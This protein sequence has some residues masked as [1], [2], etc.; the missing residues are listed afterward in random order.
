MPY[1]ETM[2]NGEA[3]KLKET[4]AECDKRRPG[5][6]VWGIILLIVGLVM[7]FMTEV[8]TDLLEDL[9][10]IDYYDTTVPIV[11][12]IVWIVGSIGMILAFVFGSIARKKHKEEAEQRLAQLSRGSYP[13]PDSG[14]GLSGGPVYGPTPVPSSG[15]YCSVCGTFIPDTAAFCPKCGK[16]KAG[17]TYDPTPAPG[18]A[19]Y[20][21]WN[22]EPGPAPEPTPYSG[23]NPEPAPAPEPV[24]YSDWNPEPGP[25][26][27]PPSEP[28]TGSPKGFK[29]AGR[30]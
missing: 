24:P 29:P 15:T 8:I 27:E 18:A 21:D 14:S 12:A 25:M 23:W 16:P 30:F 7:L 22:P 26:D 20:G 5:L 2:N 11:I 10:I 3:A 6:L 4:I 17:I 19:P 9:D 1:S 13:M 28:K